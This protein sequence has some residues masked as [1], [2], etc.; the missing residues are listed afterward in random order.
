MTVA[1]RLV[2]SIVANTTRAVISFITGMIVAR[3]LGPEQYGIFSFLL[4]SF[5]AII[6]L[7]D[8]GSSGAFFSFISKRIRSKKFFIYYIYWLLFQFSLFV[9]IILVITPDKWLHILW[10]GES[11]Q[12]I[13]IAFIAVFF[14]HQIWGAIAQIGESQRLTTKVQILG[15]VIAFIHFVLVVLFLWQDRLSIDL[16]YYLI[17]FEFIVAAIVARL[18]FPLEFSDE[19]ITFNQ[20]LKGYWV[21]CKP[22]IPYTSLG[23]IMSFS[24][25]W[26]LQHFGGAVEQAYYAVALQVSGVSLIFTSAVIRILWKEVAEANESNN[27]ERIVY[28]YKRINSILF[29]LGALISGFLLPWTEEIILLLLGDEYIEGV[30][31]MS[32]MM[33]YPIHQSLG[34]INGTMFYALELTKSY[35]IIGMLGMLISIVFSYLVLAPAS[36]DI[37]GLGLGSIGLGYKM[38]IVQFIWINFYMWWLA[39]Y[40]NWEYSFLYQ[41]VGLTVFLTLGFIVY[42]LTNSVFDQ[43]IHV[44]IRMS[45]SF[46]MYILAGMIIFYRFPSLINM[47]AAEV[48]AMSQRLLNSLNIK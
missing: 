8:M 34:Q 36:A 17:I 5:I 11:R 21:F 3:S 47:E 22:L 46:V 45:S 40:M 28:I 38:V 27:K 48:E 29:M 23:L 37:P 14:Q 7:L 19:K 1:K 20:T 31:V 24:D 16:I 42:H 15:V 33:L 43:T 44:L 6:S 39:R 10:K 41:V 35:S 26:L 32:I 25:T 13:L 4:A 2:F 12:L 9:I 30:L 18:T